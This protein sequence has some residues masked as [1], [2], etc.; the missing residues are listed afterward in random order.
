M[1]YDVL[2]TSCRINHLVQDGRGNLSFVQ[3][4]QISQLASMYQD[5]VFSAKD[6]RKLDMLMSA[7]ETMKEPLHAVPNVVAT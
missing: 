5:T 2:S 3:Q 4:N 1:R 6:L 7:E